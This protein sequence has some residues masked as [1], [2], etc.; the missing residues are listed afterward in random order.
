MY[1]N[2]LKPFK[3]RVRVVT[4]G[5][6]EHVYLTS[7]DEAISFCNAGLAVQCVDEERFTGYV[8][9]VELTVSLAVLREHWLPKEQPKRRPKPTLNAQSSTGDAG[10]GNTKGPKIRTLHLRPPVVSAVGAYA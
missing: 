6:C 8:S 5:T 3:S 7:R 1:L 9:A 4:R 2:S 10:R